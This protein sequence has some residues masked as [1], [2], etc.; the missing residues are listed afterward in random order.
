MKYQPERIFT[1]G[2]QLSDK[3]DY[4]DGELQFKTEDGTH[5]MNQ[6]QGSV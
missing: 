6:E 2:V 1:I 4:T 5:T 3:D